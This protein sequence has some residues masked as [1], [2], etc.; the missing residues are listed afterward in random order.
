MKSSIFLSIQHSE[1]TRKCI[2]RYLKENIEFVEQKYTNR[3]TDSIV[4]QTKQNTR[5]GI[6]IIGKEKI[7][8]TYT[9]FPVQL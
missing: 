6:T 1:D 3:E 2:E 4:N 7:E 8:S 9:T 5:V